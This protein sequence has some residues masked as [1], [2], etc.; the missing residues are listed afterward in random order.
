MKMLADI[1]G[2]PISGLSLARLQ[3]IFTDEDHHIIRQ[4][5]A[6]LSGHE[7]SV[8]MLRFWKN[9]SMIEIAGILDLSCSEVERYFKK[10]LSKL[11]RFC[12]ENP[13]FSRTQYR[14]AEAA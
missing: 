5:V 14:V 10:A 13:G 8:V 4:A 2:K 9:R 1:S 7:Q 11:K 12:L 6:E 3:S